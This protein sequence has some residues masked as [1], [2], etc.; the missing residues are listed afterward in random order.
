M[1]REIQSRLIPILVVIIGVLLSSSSGWFLYKL[2]EK[3]IISEFQK[4]VDERAA[5][6]YREILINFETLR[7]LA[8]LFPNGAVPEWKQFSFEAQNI[9]T[10]HLNIQ[11]LEWIPRVIHSERAAYESNQLQDYPEFE[12]TERLDQGIMVTAEERHEY[13]PVYYV[14]PL[15]GNA[16]AIGFD[17]ASNPTRLETL[18]KSRDIAIPLATASIIL[19]Q[20]RGNQKGFL[21]FLPIYKGSPATVAKRRDNLMGFVLGVYRIGDIFASS[22]P[23]HGELGIEMKIV[24]ETLIS[25]HDILHIH[26][27]GAEYDVYESINYRKELPEVWGRKWSLIASPTLSYVAVRRDFLPLAIFLSGIIITIFISLYIYLIS[28]GAATIQRIVIEKTKELNESNKALELLSRTDSLTGVANRRFMDEFIDKEWLRAIRNKL[29]ISF[30]LV[31]IDFFKLYN[32][33]YGHPEGDECL[34]KVAAKL[35][36]LVRRPGDLIARYGGEEFALVLTDTKEAELVAN[37]CRQSIEELQIA[38]KFSEAANVVTISVG[39]CTVSPDKGTDPK[40]VIDTADKA[41]YKAK[42]GGRNRVEQI[43]FHP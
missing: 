14:E 20:E 36:S 42:D 22:A 25:S 33:N 40:L 29:S 37:N 21:A 3:V 13:Y 2:E 39:L 10:R 38:H 16:A 31:D 35:K 4:D 15:I 43:V 24:D 27:S 11:A 5:S 18:E 7:S 9:L 32:D 30:I 28:R 41:L 34:K 23:P 12:I 8:I 1:D 6:L 17:L 19:V 26:E